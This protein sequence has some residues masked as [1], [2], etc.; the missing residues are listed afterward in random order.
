MNLSRPEQ[1]EQYFANV[2]IDVVASA[3][4]ADA[5]EAALPITAEVV[6][7]NGIGKTFA[8]ARLQSIAEAAGL[9]RHRGNDWVQQRLAR[10]FATVN[11]HIGRDSSAKVHDTNSEPPAA[12]SPDDYGE[13]L[14]PHHP[15]DLGPVT[16]AIGDWLRRSLSEPDCLMGAWFTT[17]SRILFSAPTG[18]GKSNFALALAAH[19]AA[20]RD[21]LHWRAH[22]PARVLFIDGEMSRRLLKRRAQDVCRR[23]GFELE[24]LFLLS[25]EDVEGF[26]PLNTPAGKELIEQ[27]I[28]KVG[29]VD[30]VIF[31]N[32]MALI[33]GD[34]KEE[35]GWQRALPLVNSLTKRSIGQLWVHHTGHD[36]TRSYGTKTREWRMDTVI[37]A[38]EQ[39]RIDTDVSFS[40]EFQKARERTPE[41]RR[42]FED[43]TIALV[44]DA[45]IC[46]AAAVKQGKPA[47]LEV[48]FLQALLDAMAG[49][50]AIKHQSWKAVRTDAWKAECIRRGLLDPDKPKS[51]SSLFSKYRRELVAHNLIACD[52]E[53]VW[54]L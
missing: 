40:L 36:A 38:T 23:L 26:Q 4:P 33:S 49:A 20:G 46:S 11:G 5:F 9:D 51:L 2:S 6:R 31:D 12:T 21:F 22:R 53:I 29:G 30:A 14:K 41:T 7:K 50:E 32:V 34:M 15:I 8:V 1:V 25:H 44:D 37:H 39:K 54:P 52:G 27:V 10:A 42:D 17:T 24:G 3:T 47:P 13:P 48:K 19:M 16:L 43:V 28:E 45:W 35:D 18:I